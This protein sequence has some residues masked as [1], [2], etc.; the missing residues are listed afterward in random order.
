MEQQIGFCTTSDGVRI[1]YATLGEGP[2]LVYVCGW[3]EHLELEWEKPFSRAFLATLAEG[4]TLIRYDM[5]GSGLSD[6]DISDFSMDALMRDL[7]AVI[8]RLSL[9]RFVLMSLG[10][11][12]GPLSVTYAVAHP[13]KVAQLILSG[14]FLRGPEFMPLERQRAL[15]E[16]VGAFG[17]PHFDFT[18]RPDIDLES[19]RGVR[20]LQK[21]SASPAAQA[22]LLRTLFSA[23]VA[24]L[25]PKI[26]APTLV[27]SGRSDRTPP[28]DQGRA[29]AAAI[30]RAKFV[31]FDG[32][33][34]LPW[35]VSHLII[36]EVH[37]FLGVEVVVPAVQARAAQGLVTVLFTDIEGSTALTER[38]GD[39][40]AREVLR[41]CERIVRDALREHGGQE[42]KAMGDGFMACFPLASGALQCAIGMQRAFAARGEEHPETPLRLRVG[43]NAGEPIAEDEDLFGTAVNLAARIARQAQGGEILASRCGPAVGSGQRV[44]VRRARR[45][46]A[47]RV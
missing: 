34:N 21:A 16:Y 26:Q 27:L 39:A 45:D 40:E 6:K 41:S 15:I 5:R 8:D 46:G 35:A 19:Q 10:M 33:S 36:P 28:F 38:L 23:D 4:S 24:A 1:A 2:P 42:I 25:A 32:I 7:W 37:R 3:P 13:E 12:A 18:D 11:L 9:E 44:L 31:S 20:E 14:G 43:M 30:P 47:A 29:L 22:T 17:F